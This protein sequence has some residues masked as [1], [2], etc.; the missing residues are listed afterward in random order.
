MPVA[1]LVIATNVNDILARALASGQYRLSRVMAT[2]SPSMDI[3]VSSNFE[4][5]LF[6]VYDRDG[7][8]VAGLM[9]ELARS[10]GFALSQGAL[11]AIKADFEA[12]RA[13]DAE[14]SAEIRNTYAG[15][16]FLADP[17][18]AIGL[19]VGRRFSEPDVPMVSLATAHAAKFPA[20]VKAAA[21]VDAKLPAKLGDILTKP[22]RFATLANDR[23]AVENHIVAHTRVLVEKV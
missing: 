11:E 15:T 1:R 20:A 8:A 4:R 22:E 13:D 3:Q 17:H 2:T 5:L 14:T 6:E 12:G 16:G 7:A 19:A 9:D 21:G 23:K 18:T 10:G